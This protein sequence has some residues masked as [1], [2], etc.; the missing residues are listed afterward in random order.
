MDELSESFVKKIRERIKKTN[1]D[2]LVLGEVWEDASTK[3]SYGEEREYFYGDDLDGVMNYVFKD[4][5]NAYVTGGSAEEFVET[6]MTITEN[7]PKESLD[8]C[9]TLIDSHD[10]VRAIN[11]YSGADV[12]NMSKEE[13]KYYRLSE[14]EYELGKARLKIASCLQYFLPGVPSLYYGDEAG[15]QGFEDPLNRRYYPWENPDEELLE[16]YTKLGAL[17]REYRKDFTE[18]A[19]IYAEDGKVRIIRGRLS[20]TVDPI[21]IGYEIKIS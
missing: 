15:I 1:P 5:I 8:T 6:V 21:N 4:A 20:L 10:T 12:S 19:E 17:R 16:H 3:Y 9:F 14:S 2:A 13:K 7:Y 11:A 18:Q